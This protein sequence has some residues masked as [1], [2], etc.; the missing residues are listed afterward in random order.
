MVDCIIKV[1]QLKAKKKKRFLFFF[2]DILFTTAFDKGS[3]H[4]ALAYVA[5]AVA[6][7]AP[8]V[9]P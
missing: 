6:I 2:I 1:I 9:L 4:N 8:A 7:F 5:N 3:F